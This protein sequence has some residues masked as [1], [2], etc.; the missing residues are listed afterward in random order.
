MKFKYN[1]D[2]RMI[3]QMTVACKTHI[4]TMNDVIN[5]E[6]DLPSNFRWRD[7]HCTSDTSVLKILGRTY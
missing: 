3:K 7:S 5:M 6:V 4:H 2:N 1:N